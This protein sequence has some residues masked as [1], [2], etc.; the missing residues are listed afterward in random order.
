M[1]GARTPAEP[2]WVLLRRRAALGLHVLFQLLVVLGSQGP[3]YQ[4][5]LSGRPVGDPVTGR[6]FVLHPQRPAQ[7]ETREAAGKGEEVVTVGSGAPRPRAAERPLAADVDAL[8]APGVTN[9]PGFLA[10]VAL[11]G[12]IVAFFFTSY[13]LVA[14][15]DLQL[16][17]LIVSALVTACAFTAFQEVRASQALLD[18]ILRDVHQAGG[19]G[20]SSV[21]ERLIPGLRVCW[22]AALFLAAA[23]Q[24]LLVSLYLTFIAQRQPAER[25]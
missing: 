19:G 2:R 6:S 8:P 17:T 24:M 1:S 21:E 3:W 13:D 12:A 7:A 20:G 11:L 15:K 18:E 22:G 14:G 16:P 5:M 25:S 9:Q 23:P 10:T 4:P